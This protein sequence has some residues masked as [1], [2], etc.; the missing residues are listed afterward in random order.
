MNS[1]ELTAEQKKA[2]AGFVEFVIALK[3]DETEA[4]IS[5]LGDSICLHCGE[6]FTAKHPVCY[7][8]RDD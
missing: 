3:W 2:V 5:L 4:V 8:W 1:D 7:C 6:A